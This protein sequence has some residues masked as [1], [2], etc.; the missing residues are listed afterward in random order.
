MILIGAFRYDVGND[1]GSYKMI[2]ENVDVFKSQISLGVFFIFK[3][4]NY[5]NLHYNFALFIFQFITL[6]FIYKGLKENVP[7]N[8][9]ISILIFFL[10]TKFHF[11]TFSGM[12]QWISISIFFYSI[13]YIRKEKILKYFGLI[14]L[15]TFFHISAIFL[16]LVYFILRINF[17]KM[18]YYIILFL[19][20]YLYKIDFAKEIFKI[21]I[22]F[23]PQYR[24]YAGTVFMRNVNLGSG[25]TIIFNLLILLFAIY[26][27]DKIF[28]KNKNYIIFINGFFIGFI[29]QIIG[30]KSFLIY[31]M[32]WYFEPF[33]LFLI[34]A[35]I[36]IFNKKNRKIVYGYILLYYISIYIKA[37]IIYPSNN[38][39]YKLIFFNL[40]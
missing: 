13:T 36:N 9:D 17:R 26:F 11:E 18:Y 28:N 29:I 31:R 34:P 2:F 4:V 35:L 12:A 1:Y 7:Y 39:I 20:F 25:L 38:V 24:T 6:Y 10:Y 33:I 5:L 27:K 32:S 3:V 40:K 16:F 30:L 37:R 14:L 15:A 8:R 23:L 22:K 19:T 21:A